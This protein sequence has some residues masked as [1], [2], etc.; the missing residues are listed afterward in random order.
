MFIHLVFFFYKEMLDWSLPTNVEESTMGRFYGGIAYLEWPG[1]L[2]ISWDIV[3]VFL[4]FLWDT[5]SSKEL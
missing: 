1:E 5:T 4:S 2:D 3:L